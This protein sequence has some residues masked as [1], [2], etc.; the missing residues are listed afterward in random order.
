[1]NPPGPYYTI[2][3]RYA[4]PKGVL[5]GYLVEHWWSADSDSARVRT[6]LTD[7]HPW[8]MYLVGPQ[9][10]LLPLKVDGRRLTEILV[11]EVRHAEET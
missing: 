11:S 5:W 8:P 9:I 3:V 4:G 1:M 6:T 7:P 2:H 10:G